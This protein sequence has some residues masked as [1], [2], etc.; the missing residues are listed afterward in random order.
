MG[1]ELRRV[2]ADWSHPK[3]NGRYLPLHEPKKPL[4]LMVAEWLHNARLWELGHHPD[5]K[6]Y[7]RVGGSHIRHFWYWDGSV[8]DPICYMPYWPDEEKTHYQWYEIVTEG[9]P[10]S[11][12]CASREDLARW[13]VDNEGDTYEEWLQCF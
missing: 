3:E 12:V 10:I 1:R 13:L 8:P 11:P 6:K 5:Q 7:T 9:T 4:L 2:P